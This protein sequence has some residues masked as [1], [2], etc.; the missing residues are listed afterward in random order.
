MEAFVS[1]VL[2]RAVYML[3]L[4]IET[5]LSA[6]KMPSDV[7]ATYMLNSI[8]FMAGGGLSFTHHEDSSRSVNK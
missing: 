8:L 6:T 5:I 2:Y 1:I 3:T 4:I 7:I